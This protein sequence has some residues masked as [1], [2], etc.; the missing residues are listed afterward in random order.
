LAL[1]ARLSAAA[2]MMA[3]LS[4]RS[5]VWRRRFGQRARRRKPG[6]R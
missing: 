2:A 6:N 1:A 4:M 5:P 3:G